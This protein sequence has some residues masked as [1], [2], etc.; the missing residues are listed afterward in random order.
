MSQLENGDPNAKNLPMFFAKEKLARGEI[1]MKDIPYMQRGGA[2]DG[3][4]LETGPIGFLKK[5]FK[6]KEKPE[7]TGEDFKKLKEGSSAYNSRLFGA[8][9]SVKNA[10]KIDFSKNGA[11]EK[12][13]GGGWFR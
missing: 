4:D 10:P 9:D 8:V 11:T 1:T 2:Y 7:S 12:K 5:A 6:P 13:S 3:S